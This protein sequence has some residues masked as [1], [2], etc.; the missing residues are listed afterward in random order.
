PEILPILTNS[1]KTTKLVR[2]LL[3]YIFSKKHIILIIPNNELVANA[4]N[5]HNTWLQDSNGI[6]YKC[7]IHRN[8]EELL[9]IVK[10]R[11]LAL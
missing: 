8:Q 2:C 6:L 5:H 4:E 3:T 11:E 1:S 9:Y 10:N 7:V